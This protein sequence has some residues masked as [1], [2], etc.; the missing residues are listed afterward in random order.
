MDLGLAGERI[1]WLEVRKSWGRGG[2]L[3]R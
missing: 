3:W 2:A 1:G